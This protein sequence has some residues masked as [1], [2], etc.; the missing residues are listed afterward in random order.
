[1]SHWASLQVGA[2]PI[3][4]FRLLRQLG[5]GGFGEVW[6]ARGPRDDPLA[7]KFLSHQTRQATAQEI[8][9]LQAI[10]HLR[11]RHLI[12][13]DEVWCHKDFI[14]I[15]MELADGSLADLF[16]VYQSDY[17][18]PIPAEHTCHYL[19]QA[20]KALD[21]LN[22]RQHLVN[23][24]RVAVQH[25]DIKPS[26]LLLVGNTVKVADFGLSGW[27]STTTKHFRK[28]GTL[29]YCPPEVFQ[30]MLS[31]QSDQFALAVTYCQLR[32][33]R[34][35]FRDTPAS[36][37]AGYVR[38]APDLSMVSAAE[39][40]IVA[41]ALDPLPQNRWE[42]CGE[43]LYQLKRAAPPLASPVAART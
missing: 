23:G 34:L 37:Q 18:V 12:R 31:L 28:A 27:I 17:G 4:G 14:V 40:P 21:F 16:D 15:S 39:R 7:L 42:S 1:M 32:G 8:R 2:E 43:F 22:A 13:M 38:P 11:H 41:R 29:D 25:C 35:P 33:G 36:F 3:P 20:A 19:T 10:R 6:E 30:G 26:N 5:V 9:S 24:I